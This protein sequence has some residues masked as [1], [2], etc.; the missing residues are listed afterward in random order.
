MKD[1]P[2]NTSSLQNCQCLDRPGRTEEI[3]QTGGDQGDMWLNVMW[4]PRGMSG[5][6]SDSGKTEGTSVFT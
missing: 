1:I 5:K 6:K 3:P 2:Q 4:D